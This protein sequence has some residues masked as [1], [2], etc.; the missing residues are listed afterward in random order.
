MD[1]GKFKSSLISLS[2]NENNLF[3]IIFAVRLWSGYLISFFL[4]P[5]QRA[6]DRGCVKEHS[7]DI[8]SPSDASEEILTR[9][10][11]QCNLNS[12]FT[13][14]PTPPL[15]DIWSNMNLRVYYQRKAKLRIAIN[16]IK[17]SSSSLSS[18]SEIRMVLFHK[19]TIV[20]PFPDHPRSASVVVT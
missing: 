6:E 4:L 20:L 16:F 3:R 2:I 17:W 18:T 15:L 8:N 14:P 11:L 13:P 19:Y 12:N 5:P 1:Y 10:V 9:H 7:Y